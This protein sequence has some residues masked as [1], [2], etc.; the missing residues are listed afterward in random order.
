MKQKDMKMFAAT[1]NQTE[2]HF[3]ADLNGPDWLSDSVRG[4]VQS[5]I[6]KSGLTTSR[7]HT[8]MPIRVEIHILTIKDGKL[9]RKLYTNLDIQPPLARMTTKEFQEEQKR[10]LSEIPEMFHYAF[11]SI[12]NDRA[13]GGG[14]E[15]VISA[16]NELSHYFQPCITEFKK[17]MIRDFELGLYCN[18]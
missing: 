8:A 6:N 7:S 17:Q 15:E 9:T 2:V 1:F 3:E 18:K 12:A 16:L 14:M 5:I 10:I 13:N 4:Q 11:T